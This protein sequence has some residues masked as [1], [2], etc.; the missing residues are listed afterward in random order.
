M[1]I[2]KELN[3]IPKDEIREIVSQM[4]ESKRLKIIHNYENHQAIKSKQSSKNFIQDKEMIF[5]NT[6]YTSQLEKPKIVEE[7][8]YKSLK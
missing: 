1:N 8:T 2:P 4:I 3:K 5:T 7:K 6:N